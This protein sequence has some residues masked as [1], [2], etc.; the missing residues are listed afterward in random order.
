VPFQDLFPARPP[1]LTHNQTPSVL[2]DIA[3]T[4]PPESGLDL[5]SVTN[6]S[7]SD[8]T[9]GSRVPPSATLALVPHQPGG[10]PPTGHSIPGPLPFPSFPPYGYGMPFPPV[11][12]GTHGASMT[13]GYPTGHSQMPPVYHPMMGYYFPPGYGQQPPPP[14]Q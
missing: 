12:P 3:T 8:P 5:P 14:M 7:A 13:N 9:D 10:V 2:E 4:T 11:P 1:P 6:P